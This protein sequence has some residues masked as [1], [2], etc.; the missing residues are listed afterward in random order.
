MRSKQTLLILFL[1]LFSFSGQH[2]YASNP[3]KDDRLNGAFI[4]LDDESLKATTGDW[5]QL[6]VN[7]KKN[8]LRKLVIQW[9]SHDIWD[10]EASPHK[11]LKNV[12][13][14]STNDV[15]EKI[16]SVADATGIKVKVGGFFSDSWW[17]EEYSLFQTA[18]GLRSA[19]A[20]YAQAIKDR[21]DAI[22]TNKP[23]A[24]I[25]EL[26]QWAQN[27]KTIAESSQRSFDQLKVD[28]WTANNKNWLQKSIAT[29]ATI[30][31]KYNKYASFDGIYLPQEIP[32]RS[33]SDEAASVLSSAFKT[34]VDSDKTLPVHAMTFSSYRAED[35]A[36]P[37]SPS[38]TTS[39]YGSFMRESGLKCLAPQDSVGLNHWD[40][41]EQIEKNAIP[42]LAACKAAC[43]ANHADIT[44][45]PE[46]WIQ[47]SKDDRRAC[48]ITRLMDQLDLESQLFPGAVLVAF[49]LNHYL[50]DKGKKEAQDLLKAVDTA[51]AGP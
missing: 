26:T 30:R 40:T 16:L 29:I 32:N 39:F 35:L 6:I 24:R 19:K 43:D 36:Q 48:N 31:E 34:L 2:S 9:V 46:C 28:G 1:V 17:D 14:T 7:M 5:K 18:Q 20:D 4:Q 23:A 33:Y 10:R 47:L 8:G 11:F 22:A 13:F 50:T 21:D 3:I 41:R 12:D 25:A 42:F 44:P 38:E 15:V 45:I 49:D 27:H 51:H 37:A